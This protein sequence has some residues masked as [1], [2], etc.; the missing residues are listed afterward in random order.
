MRK[1]LLFLMLLAA[2]PAAAA[3]LPE[4]T[5]GVE[6]S[7]A[8]FL[9]LE[10]NGVVVLTDGRA[11]KLEG[12]RLPA[13]SQDHAPGVYVDRA[14]SMLNGL[15]HREPLTLTA[16]PPKE[17]RYDRVRGQL[18]NGNGVWLQE[19]LLKAGLARVAIA[20]DRTECA[21]DLFAAEASARAARVGLWADPAYAIR[22]PETVGRDVGTFQVVEGRVLNAELKNGRA[23]LNFGADW[24]TD[25]T[26]TVDPDDMPNFRNLGV[27]PRSYVG[28]TIRVRGLVQSLNGP[29]IEVA[30]PQS[31]EIVKP[32]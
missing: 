10:R 8:Q 16:I 22:T 3:V 17:D 20:P 12:I 2:S 28:Q 19:A 18:F 32:Y 27:D 7:G 15:L 31:I 1:A 9:R 14:F 21:S 29:E 6:I 24:R 5:G 23:Y 11:M 25:F 26:V 4:C 13:G 30:N